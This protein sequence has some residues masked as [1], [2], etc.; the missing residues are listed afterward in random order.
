MVAGIGD[1]ECKWGV[2]IVDGDLE[3]SVNA[4]RFN[5]VRAVTVECGLPQNT[6]G[7]RGAGSE[8]QDAV[9]AGIRGEQV[10]L[11]INGHA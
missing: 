11:R 9:I 1:I 2:G 4:A 7:G 6:E 5:L 10:A 8:K 3:R